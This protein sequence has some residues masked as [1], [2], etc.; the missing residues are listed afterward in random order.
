MFK[1]IFELLAQQCFELHAHNHNANVQM[2]SKH[3][4]VAC[5][6]SYLDS[7]ASEHK[8]ELKLIGKLTVA[9]TNESGPSVKPAFAAMAILILWR[10]K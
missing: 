1:I 9:R 2:F 5:S 8:V 10:Q 6:P 7:I 3:S 4:T